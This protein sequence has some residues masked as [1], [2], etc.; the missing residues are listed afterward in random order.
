MKAPASTSSL[1]PTISGSRCFSASLAHAIVGARR[2]PLFNDDVLALNVTER[3]QATCC[4][5]YG[6]EW[7]RRRAAEQRD[8]L[9]A[10]HSIA[11]YPC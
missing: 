7:P 5:P 9:A 2:I 11:P 4:W 10:L 6:R 1:V 8:E 3:A